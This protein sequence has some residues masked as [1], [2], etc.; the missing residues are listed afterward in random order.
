[1]DSVTGPSRRVQKVEK[2]VKEAVA[3][4]LLTGLREKPKGF[5]SVTRVMM[6]GDLKSAKV[7]VSAFQSEQSEDEILDLLQGQA[8]DVQHVLS[9]K[10]SLRYCP[11]IT[12]FMDDVFETVMQVDRTLY[13]LQQEKTKKNG[14]NS[15]N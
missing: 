7:Y 2:E 11:K 10:L 3:S 13:N 15:N 12:F 8:H 9:K 14:D 6:P 1:M 5:I 4:Y